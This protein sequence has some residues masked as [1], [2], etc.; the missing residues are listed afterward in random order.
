MICLDSLH[1]DAC[2]GLICGRFDRGGH[3]ESSDS[4]RSI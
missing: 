3:G 4:L 1:K 2:F